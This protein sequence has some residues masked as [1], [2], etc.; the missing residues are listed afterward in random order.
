MIF[1]WLKD[2]RTSVATVRTAG[3]SPSPQP[4]S[5]QPLSPSSI[6]L[7]GRHVA[8]TDGNDI[9]VITLG[10]A[11]VNVKPWLQTPYIERWPAF[12]PDGRWLA[13]ASNETRRYEVYLRP[14]TGPGGPVQVSVEGG[15]GPAWTANGRE[16][17]YLTLPDANLK[18]VMMVAEIS[19]G[20]VPVVGTGR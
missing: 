4:L 8:A 19:P 20:P 6:T 1:T 17:F 9:F 18:R 16:L 15:D 3:S 7:D 13:Y 5:M 12:S 14:Y 2:G 11:T 10:D